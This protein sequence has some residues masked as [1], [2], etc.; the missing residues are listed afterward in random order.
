MILTWERKVAPQ[1]GDRVLLD[2]FNRNP[3]L[4][5]L[6]LTVDEVRDAVLDVRLSDRCDTVTFRDKEVLL[7][8]YS[9]LAVFVVFGVNC[10]QTIDESLFNIDSDR[11]SFCIKDCVTISHCFKDGSGMFSSDKASQRVPQVMAV[12]FFVINLRWRFPL[13]RRTWHIIF[14]T[15]FR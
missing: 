7:V 1:G 3:I 6:G 11:N 15:D 12:A 2:I 9:A 13:T 4:A 10:V 8:S 14:L 5:S